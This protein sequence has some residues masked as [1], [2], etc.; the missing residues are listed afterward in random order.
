ML[1]YGVMKLTKATPGGFIEDKAVEA[2]PN[3]IQGWSD[4]EF[5]GSIIR[6]TPFILALLVELFV[7]LAGWILFLF[8]WRKLQSFNPGRATS[9][10]CWVL[11]PSGQD[12]GTKKTNP[13]VLIPGAGY[14]LVSFVPL[15]LTLQ[16][17]AVLS[18][19]LLA[20]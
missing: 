9:V 12:S 2:I 6:P 19:S 14:G 10:E 13:L 11:R 18:I 4:N 1:E 17:R 16:V 5:L 8:G 20:H 3:L 15:A 7:C